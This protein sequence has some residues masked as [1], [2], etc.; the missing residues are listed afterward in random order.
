MTLDEPSRS[1]PA[2]ARADALAALA[3]LPAG[4][5]A[6]GTETTTTGTTEQGDLRHAPRIAWAIW[7][8]KGLRRSPAPRVIKARRRRRCQRHAPTE[9]TSH[10][11]P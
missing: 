6:P 10:V 3:H 5:A 9:A 2:P 7:G 4:A 8:V 1:A 11:R